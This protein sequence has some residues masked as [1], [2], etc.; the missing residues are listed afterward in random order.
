MDLRTKC[1]NRVK[2]L[3][4]EGTMW[5]EARAQWLDSCLECGDEHGWQYADSDLQELEN[6]AYFWA[7]NLYRDCGYDWLAQA[8]DEAEQAGWPM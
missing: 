3:Y 4:A 6:R 2:E 1:E 5:G 7:Q 8:M